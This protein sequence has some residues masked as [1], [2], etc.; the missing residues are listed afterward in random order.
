MRNR[1]AVWWGWPVEGGAC[2]RF[3]GGRTCGGELKPRCHQAGEW[4]QNR[5]D[6]WWG[7]PVEGCVCERARARACRNMTVGSGGS[8]RAT[9]GGGCCPE[10]T[11]I[12]FPARRDD[13]RN[14]PGFLATG[15][16]DALQQRHEHRLGLH[17]ESD[18]DR[19]DFGLTL[20]PAAAAAATA[21]AATATSAPSAALLERTSAHGWAAIVPMLALV[22]HFGRGAKRNVR[23]VS[24][25]DRACG[26]MVGHSHHLHLPA[27]STRGCMTAMRVRRAARNVG[28]T[29]SDYEQERSPFPSSP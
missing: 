21:A 18:L 7:W 19:A 2:V 29:A 27:T 1:R 8:G 13:R 16:G 17:V 10:L 26:S 5:R 4:L 9:A 20:L 24:G 14:R 23:G 6:A 3:T 25:R 12:P 28:T 15:L 11:V 22:A